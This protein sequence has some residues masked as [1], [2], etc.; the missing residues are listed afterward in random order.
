V[1]LS[2]LR[3]SGALA[4]PAALLA[5]ALPAVA[6]PAVATLVL[7]GSANPAAAQEQPR[8]E[9]ALVV[10]DAPADTGTVVLH[11]VTLEEA[12][13]VDSVTVGVG[14]AFAFLLPDAPEPG[15]AMYF[16]TYRHD[17]VVFFA[18]PITTLEGLG[19]PYELRAWPSRPLPPEGGSFRV[20]YRNVFIEEGPDG[21]RVTDVFEVGHDDPWSWTSPDPDGDAPVWSHPLPSTATNLQAAETDLDPG[22]IR[23]DRGA[24]E[25]TAPF[26][27]GDRLFVLRYD[28]PSIEATFP[29]VGLNRVVELLVREP[30]PVMRVEGLQADAPVEIERGSVYRRWWAEDVRD[31]APRIVLGEAQTTN[32]AWVAIGLALLLVM[33]GSWYFLKRPPPPEAAVAAGRGATRTLHQVK[34]DIAHLDEAVASGAMDAEEGA[35]RRR[36]LLAELDDATGRGR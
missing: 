21:W 17:G 22:S 7:V 34:V 36:E 10:G 23:L 24:L 14:G 16:A 6:L 18:P 15:G 33:L 3:R 29:L 4:G 30:A 32:P 35:R 2:S 1:P 26:P 11:R 8:L 20:S 28:L 25:V 12:G 5:A 13:P 9:G 19:E 31:V 27:P